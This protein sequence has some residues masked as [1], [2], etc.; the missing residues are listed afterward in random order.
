MAGVGGAHRA[1]TVDSYVIARLTGGRRTSPT[2]ATPAAPCCSTWEGRLVRRAVRLFDVPARLRC[3]GSC[4]SSASWAPPTRSVPRPVAADRRASPATAGG[5]VR[6][7]LLLPGRRASAPTGPAVRARQHRQRRR[8][9]R[10]P[11]CSPPS[12]GTSATGWSTPS[13]ARSS[14]RRRR[15][16]AP[17]RPAAR[18]APPPRSRAWPGT[19]PTAGTSSSCR[20][21]PAWALRTGTRTPAARSSAS[22]AAPPPPTWPARR[23]SDRFEVRD[24]VDTMASEAGLDVP[25]CT[26]DGGASATT[27]CC[28]LQADELGVPVAPRGRRDHRRWA[29]PSSPGSAPA[30]GGTDELRDLGA[31]PRVRADAGAGTT[32]ARPVAG[33]APRAG[34]WTS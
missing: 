1:R 2:R 22:P 23:S 34:T 25:S 27:C 31:G 19:V 17:R 11:A 26:V 24:V 33:G 16:V 3:P 5:A 30:S 14:Y 21:S 18:S 28:Q 12:P 7:G 4:R 20:R 13:R 32:A 6:A 15:A 8:S 10:T 29:Q 9:A